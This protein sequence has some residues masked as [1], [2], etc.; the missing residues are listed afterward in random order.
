MAAYS[1]S[2]ERVF[3]NTEN[4]RQAYRKPG[5]D[6]AEKLNNGKVKIHK[7]MKLKF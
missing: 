1:C 2:A 5:Q 7:K 4:I 3:Q 6:A